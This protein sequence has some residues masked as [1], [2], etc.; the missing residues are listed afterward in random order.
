[1]S[2]VHLVEGPVGAGKTTFSLRLA[3]ETGGI[4]IALDEWFARLFSPDRPASDVVA[5]YLERKDRLLALIWDHAQKILSSDRDVILELGLIQRQPRS[6]FCQR[7]RDGGFD[8]TAYVLDAP[9]DVRRERVRQRNTA[10]GATFFMVVPDHVF[11]TASNLWEAPDEIE[12]SNTR[13]E[14]VKPERR[15]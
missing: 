5:W 15:A 14:F 8:L 9:R 13:F 11:E 7:V 2:K 10:K 3:R 6:E 1:M 12:T 4:H